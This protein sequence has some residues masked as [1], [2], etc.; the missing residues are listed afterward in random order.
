[1]ATAVSSPFAVVRRASSCSAALLA[2]RKRALKRTGGNESVS[3]RLEIDFRVDSARNHL[4]DGPA[5]ETAEH[6]NQPSFDCRTSSRAH[7]ELPSNRLDWPPFVSDVVAD[8]L[9]DL[10]G[11]GDGLVFL[12]A[13]AQRKGLDTS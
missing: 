12:L 13:A 2:I 11:G 5:F 9:A 10:G 4:D 7:S 3:C 6:N 8:A 1:M